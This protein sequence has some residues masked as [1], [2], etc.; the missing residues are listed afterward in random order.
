[1]KNTDSNNEI[2]I[3]E[4]NSGEAQLSVRIENETVWLSQ[5]E[6]AKLFDVQCPAI[7]KHIK[8]IF[9]SDE[10]D[11]DSVSSI[12]EHTANDG[13]NYKTK[14]YNLDLIISIGYRINSVKA[15]HFRKWAT[16]RLREYIVRGSEW[17]KWDLHIHTPESHASEYAGNTQ[18]EKW[19]DFFLGLES[20]PKEIKVIGINDYLFLNGYKKVLEY[21][22]SGHLENLDLILPVIEF[23]LKEFVGNESLKKVNYHIVFA[24]ESLLSYKTIEAQFLSCF[25]STCNLNGDD[26]TD[27]TWG[28]VVT[29]D[30]VIDLGKSIYNNTPEDKR[31]GNNFFEIGFNSLSYSL[32]KLRECLGEIKEPN[33]YLKNKYVKVIGKSEWEDFRW[34]GSPGGK[35]NL[36]N[37][38]NFVFSASPSIEQAIK[39]IESLKGQGV[40]SRLLHCSDAH[41]IKKVEEEGVLE[42]SFQDTSSKDLGHCFTWI[43]GESSFETLRQAFVDYESRVL[44]QDRN[45]AD[46]KNSSPNLFI[47]KL[48]YKLDEELKVLFLSKDLN[49]VIGKRGAGKSVLLKHIALEADDPKVKK[50]EKLEEFKIY[51]C[52]NNNEGKFI[53]YIPQNYLSAI[54]YEDGEKYNERD[55]KLKELL[56]NNDLFKNA[57]ENKTEVV[58][59]I[60]LNI[61]AHIKD[62]LKLD[63]QI[64]NT[65]EQ[66]KPLG[67]IEDKEKA[68]KAKQKEIEKFGKVDITDKEIDNQ[69]KYFADLEKLNKKIS[70]TK[71]DIQIIT[72]INNSE[73][74]SL[75]KI[76]DEIFTGLSQS[77]LGSIEEHI[78]S[79]SDTDMKD[80]LSEVSK[81]LNKVLIEK[82][83]QKISTEKLLESINDKLQKNKTIRAILK[84]IN[85]INSDKEEISK[86][87]ALIK[88]A[89]ENKIQLIKEAVGFYLSFESKVNSIVDTLKNEFKNFTFIT[90]DFAVSYD[91]AAYKQHFF[92]IFIDG[93][94]GDEFKIYIDEKR[95]FDEGELSSIITDIVSGVVGIKT[96]QGDKES[97]LVALLSCRY[98]I[99]FTKSVKYK[100]KDGENLSDFENMTGGQK[101]MALLDLIFNLS[102]SNYPIIIDQPENDI[103]ISGISNDLKKLILQQKERRQVI[104]ATH[105]P[106]LLLLTD[107]EN[108]IIANN[109]DNKITYENGGIEKM[110]IQDNIIDILEGGK[111]ALK[112]RMNK[113]NLYN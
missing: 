107:S 4:G 76:D 35:K 95:D 6:I 55:K 9:E 93:R 67:K 97:A 70:L 104:I 51:W 14:F 40:N 8:N 29:P 108:V 26:V 3:Y 30:S 61:V 16:A 43:K 112:K 90:F 54:T 65:Q 37:S 81:S 57:D 11:K 39:N 49:S 28:G 58:D 53:E 102:K 17:K 73:K 110:K 21:K 80:F 87:A 92:D 113:L 68:V 18:D 56:F 74:I 75:L 101:A 27:A 91:V 31:E 32:E 89:N 34:T 109:V 94:S 33:T 19:N 98:D 1:M 72:N 36:I 44:I 99:D 24:D 86:L 71:Q 63:K 106:N 2:I 48:E 41:T 103:D 15:T 79:L 59:L 10:L 20:L 82:N 96:S 47:N 62:I 22:E 12:L 52:D 85:K 50:I 78:K 77:I 60:E 7:T 5:T 105:S 45:P 64:L 84:E 83:K 69:A 23:R 25:R 38:T 66:M 42:S 100:D 111:E 13:K 46:S 88:E